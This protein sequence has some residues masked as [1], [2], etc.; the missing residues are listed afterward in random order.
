MRHPVRRLA[1]GAG[2]AAGLGAALVAPVQAAE[3][4]GAQRVATSMLTFLKIGVGARAVG[5]GET[6]TPVADDA[7]TLHWNPAGL[8]E[9][10]G[11]RVHLTHTE[12]PAD[13]DYENLIVT[14]P[15]R[16]WDGGLGFQIASLRTTLDYT[17]EM[18]P[19][20]N[21][22]SFDYSDLLL[23]AGFAR[24]FTDRFTFGLGIKYLREDLGSDV[25]G[26]VLDSWSLDMGT[27]FR[28]P[29]R[30]FRVSMA[31]TNFGPDFQP[32]GG[33]RSGAPVGPSSDVEYASFSPASI[34]AFGVALEPLKST[35]YRLMTA[36][37]FD[38][39][40][41]GTELIKGGAELWFDEM[42]A[43]RAGWNPRSD[44]MDFSAGLGFRGTLAGRTLHVDYAYTDGN[45][46]GRIDRFSLE[47]EF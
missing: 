2:L 13:I 8:A 36:T 34:F 15:M 33:F 14:L 9:L 32:P 43:L 45:S 27:V 26:S 24:Q 38:H 25:G 47:L 10:D 29:F 18:E 21:G 6:F 44:E 17:S 40:A 30:G 31:W 12:W 22:R 1:L 41:D 7:T 23:G 20:P 39:P 5:L 3:E 11:R 4:L 46:L 37:Q 19:L 35:H 16:A 42:V 28:L